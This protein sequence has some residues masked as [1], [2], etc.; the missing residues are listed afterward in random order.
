MHTYIYTHM[1]E[2]KQLCTN[3]HTLKEIHE[4]FVK[5]HEKGVKIIQNMQRDTI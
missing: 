3:R 4:I 1:P 2:H 5:I